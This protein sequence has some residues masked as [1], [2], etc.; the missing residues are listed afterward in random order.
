MIPAL[1]DVIISAR[2][3]ENLNDTTNYIAGICAPR[4][5][6]IMGSPA[7]ASFNV[8]N[9]CQLMLQNCAPYDVTI[10]SGDMVGIIDL[11]EKDLVPLNDETISSICNEI[12]D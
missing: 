3:F 7:W 9:H 5:P 8:N 1:S 10:E 6:M 11:E 4:T 12:Q 2:T